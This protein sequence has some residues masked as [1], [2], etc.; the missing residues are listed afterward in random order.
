MR[1]RLR[2]LTVY[3]LALPIP[4]LVLAVLPAGSTAAVMLVAVWAGLLGNVLVIGLHELGH[5][6][7]GMAVGMRPVSLTA[8]PLL[9]RWTADGVRPG[10]NEH[11][12]PAGLARAIPGSTDRLPWR[13]GWMVAGGPLANLVTA[14]VTSAALAAVFLAWQPTKPELRAFLHSP[15]GLV[16][17]LFLVQI[18]AQSLFQGLVNL[19]PLRSA[20]LYSDGARLLMLWRGGERA[21]R[22]C[23]IWSLM[24]GY[25]VGRP[26]AEWDPALIDRALR[27]ADGSVDELGAQSLA[28]SRAM[29]L[30]DR[31]AAAAT[32]ARCVEIVEKRPALRP[33]LGC[34]AAVFEAW[35]NRDPAAARAW[36]AEARG[37]FAPEHSRLLAESFVL[38]AE[39]RTVE[40]R[41]SIERTREALRRLPAAEM[42]AAPAT[43]LWL[44][45][46]EERLRAEAPRAEPTLPV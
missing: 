1:L 33:A 40:A 14:L 32:L 37:V 44:V 3:L 13:I 6:V 43:E 38:A 4:L 10:V 31:D 36:L 27:P 15:G 34:T 21:D 26:A 5:L 24:A 23:A 8:G 39:G 16:A 11:W 20:G 12:R 17:F 35:V 28:H 45:R 9:L 25:H 19:L 22:W 29:E 7:G 42:G 41:G 46:L 18:P 30:D 2:P